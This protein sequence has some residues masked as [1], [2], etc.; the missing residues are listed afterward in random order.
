MNE[1]LE[2]VAKFHL[3]FTDYVT[4]QAEGQTLGALSWLTL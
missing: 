2:Y 4:D 1:L 3:E